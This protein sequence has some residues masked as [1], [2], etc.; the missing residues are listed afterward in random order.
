MEQW[1]LGKTISA[2]L[3][4]PDSYLCGYA[5]A[6]RALGLVDFHLLMLLT[7]DKASAAQSRPELS[8]YTIEIFRPLFAR[9][10]Y[11]EHCAAG[12][13]CSCTRAR[14]GKGGEPCVSVSCPANDGA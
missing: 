10:D 3:I 6:I 14:D 7:R 1:L 9:P 12:C 8:V 13:S 4:S 5:A 2:V 11:G